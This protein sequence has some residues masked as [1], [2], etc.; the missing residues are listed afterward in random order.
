MPSK[1]SSYFMYTGCR[2]RIPHLRRRM[3]GSCQ[4]H[5]YIVISYISL[6]KQPC[7][8]A[9]IYGIHIGISEQSARIRTPTIP[10]MDQTLIFFA[11]WYCIAAG[12][13]VFVCCLVRMILLLQPCAHYVLMV[14]VFLYSI[15]AVPTYNACTKLGARSN[16]SQIAIDIYA[17]QSKARTY[18]ACTQSLQDDCDAV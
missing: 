16:A 18:N 17:Q 7:L 9:C 3:G 1:I 14:I 10:A 2:H 6:I 12:P 5:L 13:V 4:V 8:Y 11:F 15:I